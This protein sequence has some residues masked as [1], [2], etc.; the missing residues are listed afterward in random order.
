MSDAANTIVQELVLATSAYRTAAVAKNPFSV[1]LH[2]PDNSPLAMIT[3]PPPAKRQ[4]NEAPFNI[5][6]FGLKDIGNFVD[7][8]IFKVGNSFRFRLGAKAAIIFS[9]ETEPTFKAME[10]LA[11]GQKLRSMS[12]DQVLRPKLSVSVSGLP[13][14]INTNWVAGKIRALGFSPLKVTN[15][16]GNISG[17]PTSKFRVE[18][19]HHDN[20]DSF[21]KLVTLGSF[22]VSIGINLLFN[23]SSA[24]VMDT[25]PVTASTLTLS[26]AR[27]LAPGFRDCLVMSESDMKCANCGKGHRANWDSCPAYLDVLRSKGLSRRATRAKLAIQA[28]GL[29]KVHKFRRSLAERLLSINSAT[30]QDMPPAAQDMPPAAQDMPPAAQDMPP[31]AHELSPAAEDL[32]PVAHVPPSEVSLDSSDLE[33]DFNEVGDLVKMI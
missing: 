20:N 26:A 23:V 14:S 18:L 31:A 13:P 1:R 6:V 8:A 5:Y 32:P 22:E 3:S 16:V 21:L 27:V 28:S 10:D 33:Y 29:D 12:E 30:A 15:I 17:R 9:C 19:D 7:E 11:R 24:R 4:C 25:F 2:A